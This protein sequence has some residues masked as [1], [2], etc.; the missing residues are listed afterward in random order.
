MGLVFFGAVCISFSAVFVKLADV[1]PAVSAF[2]RLGIGG[3]ALL[4]LLAAT[5]QIGAVRKAI[6]WPAVLCG[7]FFTG[8]LLC[9]HGSINRI[10]PGLATLVGNFQVFLLAI[11]GAIQARRAPT[12]A[13][14][15]GMLLAMAGLYLVVG[16]GFSGQTPAFRQGVLLGLCTAVFYAGY[17]LALKSAVT[18]RGR[19]GPTAAM[20][21]LSLI[22]AVF[23]GLVVLATGESF[24][25]PTTRSVLSLAGL[26][27][28]GQ[29][30][31]WVVISIGLSRTRPAVAGLLL[32]L[33]PTLSY[34]W[35]VLF[36]DKPTGI[37]EACGVVLALGGI[38]LG[39]VRKKHD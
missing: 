22:G 23:L 10:G 14:L 24:V 17:I 11:I 38:A 33:Q 29:G 35:D 32:L 37:T 25:L 27:L 6:N 34:V 26:G 30:L 1:A 39:S 21:V 8:D 9:W 12:P 5:G 15:A 13:F 16:R 19:A 18:D 20:A 28:V 31:G 36:F 3:L 4:A 2:Y 7:L